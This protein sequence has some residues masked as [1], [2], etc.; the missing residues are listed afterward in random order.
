MPDGEELTYDLTVENNGT[1]DATGVILT[2]T[3]PTEVSFGVTVP[4]WPTCDEE[5]GIVTCDLGTLPPGG[6]M[7][8]T[9]KVD[10]PTGLSGILFN[11]ATVTLNEEDPLPDNNT[12][13]EKT[14][15]ITIHS[16]GFENGDFGDWHV[17]RSS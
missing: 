6:S 17:L 2:N 5:S 9:V 8:V 16:D 10:V 11:S 4:G 14:G 13:V 12:A 15:L 7:L 1:R 3:L